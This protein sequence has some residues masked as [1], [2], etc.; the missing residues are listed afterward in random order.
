MKNTPDTNNINEECERIK[1][2]IM[3][4]ANKVI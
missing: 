3:D 2:A 4:A 1:E